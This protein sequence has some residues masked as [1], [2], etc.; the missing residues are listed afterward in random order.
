MFMYYL[1][2]IWI[3]LFGANIFQ[4]LKSYN[5]N[6]INLIF[7]LEK[8][9]MDKCDVISNSKCNKY[10]DENNDHYLKNN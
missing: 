4:N 10:N 8:L 1:C 6:L 7:L 2:N 5:E 3:L 9:F